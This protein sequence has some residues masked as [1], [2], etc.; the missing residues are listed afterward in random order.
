M[1]EL[2]III[3]LFILVFTLAT[4]INTASA[5]INI[6]DAEAI[7]EANLSCGNVP[8]DPVPV[9]TIFTCNEEA[10]SKRELYS[11]SIL[12][13]SSPIIEIFIVN[14]EAAFDT[15]LYA[16]TIPTE[17]SPVKEIFIIN[18]EAKIYEDL[19]YPKGLIKDT[20]LPLITNVTTTNISYNSVTIMWNT[21][22]IADSLVKYGKLSGTYT[23]HKEDTWFVTNHTIVLTGL[24]QGTK[25]YFIVNSADLSGNSDE[26][27]E[28]HFTTPTGD[29]KTQT[30]L[31]TCRTMIPES[32]RAR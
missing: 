22:E 7:Y 3:P 14:E 12:T 1:K 8:T 24:S 4:L 29:D 6:I 16:V 17:P 30:L 21:D 32:I 10:I 9:E 11:V 27:A 25:Y 20:S 28:Y 26:S 18:E 23:E 2:R 19:S 5:G 31:F 15:N 13:Q